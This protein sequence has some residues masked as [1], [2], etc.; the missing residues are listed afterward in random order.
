M[1]LTSVDASF[2]PELYYLLIISYRQSGD[3]RAAQRLLREL[4]LFYP[5]NPWLTKYR[6]E[7]GTQTS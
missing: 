7:N 1:V 6:S 5:T 2:K 3:E 4:E